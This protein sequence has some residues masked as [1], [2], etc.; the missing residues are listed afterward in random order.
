M[1]SGSH[2]RSEARLNQ[3][4]VQMEAR[5]GLQTSSEDGAD[6]TVAMGDVGPQDPRKV[7]AAGEELRGAR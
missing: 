7:G 4:E 2:G 3:V 6:R 5:G 1:R